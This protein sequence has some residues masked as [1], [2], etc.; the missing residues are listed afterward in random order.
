VIHASMERQGDN[1]GI[2]RMC[3]LAGVSRAALVGLPMHLR[4]T[5]FLNQPDLPCGMWQLCRSSNHRGMVVPGRGGAVL[6]WVSSKAIF[7]GVTSS[8]NIL[9]GE[10][11][12]ISLP[13]AEP[14]LPLLDEQALSKMAE[15]FQARFLAF[16]LDWL[17]KEREAMAGSISARSLRLLRTGRRKLVTIYSPKCAAI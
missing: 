11:L 7:L 14:G 2:E 16:R 4:P 6:D 1:L 3:V 15:A 12:R 9:S 17:T 8:A 5:W 10:A 13:P